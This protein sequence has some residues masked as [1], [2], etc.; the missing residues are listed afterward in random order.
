MLNKIK[1]IKDNQQFKYF[2]N[3]GSATFVG[4]FLT[5]FFTFL[6]TYIVANYLDKNIAGTYRY[7]YSYYMIFA[8]F[9][10]AGSNAALIRSTAKGYDKTY[11]Y[12]L[13]LKSIWSISSI[14]LALSVALYYFLHG[15]TQISLGFI[16]LAMSVPIFEISAAINPYLQGKHAFWDMTFFSSFSKFLVLIFTIISVFYFPNVFFILFSTIFLVG[17]GQ[18]IFAKYLYEKHQIKNISEKDE[19][20]TEFKTYATHLTIANL[21]YSI[22]FQADKIIMFTYFGSIASAGYWIATIVPL[23]IQRFVSSMTNIYFGKL[24]NIEKAN[25]KYKLLKILSLATV[26]MIIISIVYHFI[27]PYIFQLFFPK[28]LEY[29]KMSQLA[30]WNICFIP[31]AFLWTFYMAK[32]DVKKMYFLHIS[33]PLTQITLYFILLPTFGIYGLLYGML[34][35]NFLFN[36]FALFFFLRK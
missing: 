35:K 9:C 28:Y 26:C 32:G 20:D 12:A 2:L 8:V 15:N 13:K 23:E 1:I 17:I 22:G 3:N 11:L 4:Y 29:I 27:S 7:V 34:I 18:A 33:D 14:L 5:A 16:A 31:F 25:I 30:F 36:L 21:F 6:V 10:L 19:I 24:V